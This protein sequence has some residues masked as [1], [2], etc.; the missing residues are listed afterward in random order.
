MITIELPRALGVT[1]ES[2]TAVRVDRECATVRDALAELGRFSEAALDRVMNERGE[3]REHVNVFVND[4]NIRFLD[5][6]DSPVP[7]GSTVHVIAAISGG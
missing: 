3:I 4:E 5:G 6:L 1:L 2:G 7:D